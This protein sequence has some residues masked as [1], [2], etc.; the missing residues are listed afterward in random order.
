MK[1]PTPSKKAALLLLPLLAACA[2]GANELVG[3]PDP[4]G[5]VAGFWQ[6]LWHGLISPLAFLVS[7]FNETVS[8]YEVHNNGIWY[9][10]GFLLGAS[11]VFGGG[12]S[13]AAKRAG[14]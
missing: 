9:N 5:T 7:L 6:G 10:L 14:K 4:A 11:S 2:A 12:G 1:I 13:K 8:V 3:V